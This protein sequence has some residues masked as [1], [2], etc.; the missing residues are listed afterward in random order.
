MQIQIK[1]RFT[2][3]ILFEAD[4]QSVALA[5]V[6]AVERD[7]DLGGANLRGANLGD[8]DLGGANLRGAN[9]G[10]ADLGGANLGGANLRGANLGG[11]NLGGA[12]LG[13]AEGLEAFK[14]DFWSIL[15]RSP[16]EVSGLISALKDGRIDGSVYEGDCACLVGTI[17]NLR[18]CDYHQIPDVQP[19]SDRPAERWFMA[20]RK[21]DTPETNPI[22][23]ITVEWAEEFQAVLAAAIKVA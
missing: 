18:H 5:V 17:A 15:F 4:A 22:S 8:A 11:A 19:S 9:L 7:A 20:I 23:R 2:G 14:G 6:K 12:N 16:A 3:A 13:D 21:G 1:H 10:D